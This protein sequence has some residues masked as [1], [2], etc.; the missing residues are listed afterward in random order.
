MAKAIRKV[1]GVHIALREE[2]E[3]RGWTPGRNIEVSYRWGASDAS[4]IAAVTTELQGLQPDVIV[5]NTSVGLRAIEKVAAA[6]PIVFVGVS[7]PVAQGFVA[8]LAHPGAN[9]T[10]F[11]NLEPT[12]GAK[13]FD[14]LKEAA[15][16]TK[17]IAFMYNPGNPGSSVTLSSA[18]AAASTGGGCLTRRSPIFPPSRPCWR[19]SAASRAGR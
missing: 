19:N 2:L 10:G 15:P 8:S 13:W 5:I 14:L 11:S 1:S 4:W 18:Q 9:I 7:E 17:R 3:S 12:L 16:Q 6:T